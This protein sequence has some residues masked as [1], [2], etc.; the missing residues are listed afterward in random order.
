MP[1]W[2]LGIVAF[3]ITVVETFITSQWTQAVAAKRRVPAAWWAA[4]FEAVLMV[5]ILLLV[6]RPTVVAVPVLV[7]AWLG[8][9][10]SFRS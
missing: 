1:D 5:D 2:A 6:E 7:G 4:T 8:A 3:V 9:Y 10:W